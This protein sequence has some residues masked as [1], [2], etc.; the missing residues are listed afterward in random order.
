MGMFSGIKS[1]TVELFLEAKSS[2]QGKN[3]CVRVPFLLWCGYVLIKYWTNPSYTSIL[4][5][6]NLGIHELGHLVFSFMGEFMGILGGTLLQILAPLFGIFN[7]YRQS[8]FFAIAL[9]FGWLS[10]SLFDVARYVADAS[11]M[12]LPLVSPFGGGDSVIHDWNYLLS[13]IG[14]L[15]YDTFCALLIKGA[16]TLSMLL[17]L[18]GGSWVLLQMRKSAQD[19]SFSNHYSRER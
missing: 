17:C 14:L 5:P 7:F 2:C 1:Y 15:Q 6:L 18:A 12:E 11:V 16:S 8:D 9:S 3:W 19:A 4:S 13:R 10:V